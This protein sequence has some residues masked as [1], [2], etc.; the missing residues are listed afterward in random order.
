[1]KFEHR[2][3]IAAPREVVRDF[4]DD[5]PRAARCFPGLE[6]LNEASDGSYE[7]RVAVRL[8]PIGFHI[9]GKA[10]VERGG[11]NWKVLGEGRDRRAGAG[12]IATIE[13]RLN[14]LS[15]SET[16]VLISA[17]LQFSGR[18]AELGQPL[19]KRKADAMVGEF[20]ANLRRALS[21]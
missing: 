11:E 19:I 9:A 15:S 2:V 12:V 17:E 5:V 13:A 14:S 21:G 4:L 6:E 20:T 7:G 18:L 3:E 8:G 16:E 1:M 10:T